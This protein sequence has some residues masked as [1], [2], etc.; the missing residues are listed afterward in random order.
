M[1]DVD[2]RP[3]E[4]L[5]P[6]LPFAASRAGFWLL[7]TFCLPLPL[8][9]IARDDTSPRQ[10]ADVRRVNAPYNVSFSE[11]AIFWFGQVTPIE[12]YADVRVRYDETGLVLHVAAIDRRLWY[13]TSPAA[14][15]LVDW[16]AATV[17]LDTQGNAGSLPGESAYRFDAQLV[18]WEGRQAY[19]AAYQG[20]GSDWVAAT[21]PFTTTSGWRGD[22]PNNDVNDRGWW[23]R[24]VIPFA[25][26]GMD[27][28]SLHDSVWGLAVALH[29]RDDE[30]NTPIADQMW[31]ET[32]EPQQPVTWGQLAFGMP[33]YATPPVFPSGTA[34]IRHGLEGAVVVDADVGGSSVCGQAAAP[35][36]FPTWGTLNY[37]GK[38][39]LN[40]QNQGDIADWPCFSK[41]YVTFPLDQVPPDQAIISATLTLYLWGGAGEGY[42]PGPQPSLIQ[43]LSIG[44]DW[45]EATITWNNAPLA[46]ENI[47]AAWVQPVESYP[48]RPGIPYHW[49]VS[50][51]AAQAYASGAPL[52]LALYESDWAYHSGKYFDTCDTDEW[53]AQG[54]PTLKIAWGTPLPYSLYLPYLLRFPE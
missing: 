19:Q 33:A 40:I 11:S 15:D 39:F 37:A 25:S 53:G 52:R 44:T 34:I 20:D 10:A 29:D 48:G 23:L 26:L 24:Y 12:N 13:D 28:P 18:W 22:A 16:D 8:F 38:D 47:S 4:R 32:M 9:V 31:P 42:E 14:E 21:I 7:V 50:L 43:V 3:R 6:L 49:D 45:Q 54:R 41:Y 51:A 2:S 17:Y 30:G 46:R 5:W 35:D 27:G 1:S 36:Y